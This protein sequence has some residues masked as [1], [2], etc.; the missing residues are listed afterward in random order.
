MIPS[1]ACHTEL[2]NKRKAI[3]SGTFTEYDP[4][5]TF[6]KAQGL[7][8]HLESKDLSKGLTRKMSSP[9]GNTSAKSSSSNLSQKDLF[10]KCLE[11]TTEVEETLKN[12]HLMD[13]EIGYLQEKARGQD[14]KNWVLDYLG[15]TEIRKEN[16]VQTKF[17]R[18]AQKI[19]LEEDEEQK[20]LAAASKADSGG[21]GKT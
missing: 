13:F 5:K 4:Q 7:K 2:A 9:K 3:R 10:K 15:M 17:L 19:G 21:K 14:M 16:V 8:T 6:V 1:P 12:I 18:M 11:K 20:G